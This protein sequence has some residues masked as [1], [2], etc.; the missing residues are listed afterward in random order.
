MVIGAD[1]SQ[2]RL[3]FARNVGAIDHAMLA[4]ASDAVDQIKALT[5]G[6]GCEVSVDC[7]GSPQGR[8]LALQ[9]HA[10]LGTRAM[11]GEGNTVILT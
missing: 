7:S 6:Y 9:G 1:I 3:D 8:L 10:P 11:V 2:E 5:G 4:D